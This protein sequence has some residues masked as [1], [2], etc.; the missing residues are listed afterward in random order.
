M[1]IKT[2]VL[3]ALW[4][5]TVCASAQ[6]DSLKADEL[7]V[8]KS[9]YRIYEESVL[10]ALPSFGT[11]CTTCDTKLIHGY[12]D[13]IKRL[14]HRPNLTDD[15]KKFITDMAILMTR[16]NIYRNAS[17]DSRWHSYAKKEI[18]TA[19]YEV[20]QGREIL[21]KI[22]QLNPQLEAEIEAFT[23]TDIL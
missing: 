2:Y 5:S 23:S 6:E 9:L 12:V 1:H 20:Q 4:M 11:R 19:L 10:K 22:A 14:L 18:I 15:E 13:T 21:K 16:G 8:L 3:G 7:K 17:A